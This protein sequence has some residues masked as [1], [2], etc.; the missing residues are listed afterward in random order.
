MKNKNDISERVSE[1]FSVVKHTTE[2]HAKNE[3]LIFLHEDWNQR[4]LM[5]IE[6]CREASPEMRETKVQE[7]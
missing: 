7:T 3:F 2:Q 4:R 5:Q 6:F 1:R